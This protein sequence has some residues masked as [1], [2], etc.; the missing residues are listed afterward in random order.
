MGKPGKDFK[1][2]HRHRLIEIIG[3]QGAAKM[4]GN[5]VSGVEG[6]QYVPQ[7]AVDIEEIIDF[8]AVLHTEG[9]R[10]GFHH[11]SRY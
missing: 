2:C 7:D 6:P 9:E 10:R 11:L 5:R 8:L 4:D 3:F 1:P